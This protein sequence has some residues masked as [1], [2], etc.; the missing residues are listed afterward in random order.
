MSGLDVCCDCS[1]TYLLDTVDMNR[2]EWIG[3]VCGIIGMDKWVVGAGNY[4]LVA[5]QLGSI[6]TIIYAYGPPSTVPECN[7]SD[8]I[9]WITYHLFQWISEA[10][11]T[12][13][14][15]MAHMCTYIYMYVRLDAMQSVRLDSHR[16]ILII[17]IITLIAK[18]PILRI[19]DLRCQRK[20]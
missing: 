14:I 4:E 8:P 19:A 15:Y 17:I 20:W 2:V 13:V 3:M 5:G 1:R 11:S 18:W 7:R 10:H 6:H 12:M 16:P 9:N